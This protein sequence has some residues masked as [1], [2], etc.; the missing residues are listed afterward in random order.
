MKKIFTYF[1]LVLSI[2]LMGAF[3]ACNPIENEQTADLGLNIKTFFP[4]KVVAGAPMTINGTGFS[5][6]TEIVFPDGVTV[7]NFEKV[8]GEMIRLTAPAGISS[9]GGKLI[10]R[11]ST[12]EVESRQEISLGSTAISGYSKLDG[13]EINGG[14]QLTIYGKDL[15]FISRIELL[16]TDG[17][18]LILEDED[19]Y[20][21]GTS[22]V[23]ITIPKTTIYDGAFVGKVYTFDGK[24][25]S[26]PELTYIPGSEGGGHWETVE[27]IIWEN[28]GTHGAVSWSGDY[29]F[30]GEGHSTGEEIYTIPAD[31]WEKMKSETFYLTVAATDPQIR[32]T[33]GWWTGSWTGGDFQPGNER[34]VDNG[35]GTWTLAITLSDPAYL[36]DIDE[37]HLL[38]TGDRFTPLKIFFTE[39]IWVDGGGHMEIV[40]TTIWKNDGSHGAVAWSG[41]YRFAGEGHSTGEEIYT[42]PADIWEKM[43]SETFYLD[44]EATD[45]QIRVTTGWWSGSWTGGDFQP[46]NERLVDNGDGTWTLTITLFDPEY[47]NDLD[48]QHLLF[49]GDR[50]TPLEIY[51]AEEVWVDDGGESGPT[52]QVIWEGDGGTVSWS[53]QYRFGLEGNDGNNECIATFPQDIW[54]KLK[55]S[56]F[57]IELTPDADW[58]NVRVTN[59]WWDVSWNVGDI[60]ANSERMIDNGDGTYHIEINISEDADFLASVDQKHILFTGEGY[61]LRKIYFQ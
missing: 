7:T 24:E 1:G 3:T 60:G 23:V 59:G 19:F 38:F 27:T 31:I 15:E 22:T 48:E 43:K 16:D 33:T 41:D 20:R 56:T 35:D 25:F 4:T 2:A 21:K 32:V 40:K 12:E 51:F 6:V 14:D 49:T 11:T 28:D 10:V 13:E 37:Q 57:Y 26:L 30:A 53:G 34:L 54:D 39:D 44:V 9:G 17:N 42:I 61:T 47:L 5:D 52:Q 55:S 46:G 29:R 18:P 50:F 8:G 36:D 58:Y 45:P